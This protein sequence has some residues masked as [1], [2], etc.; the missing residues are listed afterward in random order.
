MRWKED[1]R[2]GVMSS[3]IASNTQV[4]PRMDWSRA[5]LA[6]L[7]ATVVMTIVVMAL[8][9]NIM[10]SLGSM[11]VGTS[12]SPALQYAAGGAVHLMIGLFYGFVFAALFGRVREWNR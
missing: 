6:G 8:G 9:T 11:I 5:F 7:A 2:G 3:S 4:H 10:K 1:T 12:A